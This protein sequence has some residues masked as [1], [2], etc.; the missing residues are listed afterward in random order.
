MMKGWTM[1]TDE[2]ELLVLRRLLNAVNNLNR[3]QESILNW[4]SVGE[5]EQFEEI[6]DEV[7]DVTGV[8]IDCVDSLDDGVEHEHEGSYCIYCGEPVEPSHVRMALSGQLV[9]IECGVCG[10]E[11]SLKVMNSG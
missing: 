7:M 1:T 8:L 11:Y 6:S 5:G 4:R 10:Q 3:A 2:R 9:D